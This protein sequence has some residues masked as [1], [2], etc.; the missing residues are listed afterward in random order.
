M[1]HFA[2][3][4]IVESNHNHNQCEQDPKLNRKETRTSCLEEDEGAF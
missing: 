1:W 2:M 4:S 3:H